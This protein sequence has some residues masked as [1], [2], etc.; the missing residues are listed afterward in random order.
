MRG[1]ALAIFVVAS[2]LLSSILVAV[3]V[4][5]DNTSATTP[6]YDVAWGYRKSHVIGASAGA[7]TLY[8]IKI[9]VYYGS[10]SDLGAA[11]YT[12]SHC[13]TDFGDI[14]FT[15]DDGVTLLDYWMESKTNSNNAV[16]WVEVADSLESSAQTIYVYYSNA[17]VATTSNGNNTFTFFDDFYSVS[18]S[19]WTITGTPTVSSHVVTVFQSAGGDAEIYSKSTFATGYALR[20][21]VNSQA[22]VGKSGCIGFGTSQRGYTWDLYGNY[23]TGSK[24]NAL[25]NGDGT[26]AIDMGNDG[27]TVHTYDL[28]RSTTQCQYLVDATSKGTQTAGSSASLYLHIFVDD[29]A[30]T[31]TILVD[32]VVIRKYIVSEPAHSTWGSEE[33]PPPAGWSPTFTSTP[34]TTL[35]GGVAYDY[36]VT[37][38]ESATVTALNL[39]AWA[40]LLH[41]GTATSPWWINGTT[42][43]AGTYTFHLKANS[44]AGTL[45]AYQNWTVTVLGWLANYNYRLAINITGSTAGSV[46]NYPIN[47]T[48]NTGVGSNSG[49]TIY[50]N[51][52]ALN[53]PND[54]RFTSSDGVSSLYLWRGKYSSSSGTWW[55]N[56]TSIPDSPIVTKFY[57]YYG[58]A[59]ATDSS[60][61]DHV[62]IFYDTFEANNFNK[63]DSATGWD[64]ATS[65]A[66]H[67]T[68]VAASENGDGGLLKAITAI[69]TR[70]MICVDAYS[71]NN[72]GSDVAGYAQ[73]PY[74]GSGG[75]AGTVYSLLMSNGNFQVYVG[76]LSSWPSNS[77]YSKNTWYGMKLGLDIINADQYAWHNG[78]YMGV[79]DLVGGTGSPITQIARI[80]CS[81][82]TVALGHFYLDDILVGNWITPEPTISSGVESGNVTYTLAFTSSA[83]TTVVNPHGYSYTAT[84]NHT[85]TF[86]KDSCNATWITVGSSN[87]TAYGAPPSIDDG[88]PRSYTVSIKAT[89]SS[90][91]NSPVYQNYTIWVYAKNQ[92]TSSA[93]TTVVN[94]NLY[95]Y[96]CLANLTVT[97]SLTGNVTGWASIDAQ[98]WVNGTPPTVAVEEYFLVSIKGHNTNSGDAYQN[99]TLH[100]YSVFAITS[101]EILSVVNPDLYEYHAIANVPVTWSVAG[102]CTSWISI[103]AQGWVNGSPPSIN[104]GFALSYVVEIHAHNDTVGDTYQNYTLWVYAELLITSSPTTLVVNPNTYSYHTVANL[105][106]TWSLA[107]NVTGWASIDVNGWVNGTPPTVTNLQYYLVE[108][109]A[110][111]TGSGNKYQ[112]FTLYVYAEL[113]ISSSAVTSAVNPDLYHYHVIANMVVTWSLAGNVTGWASIDAQGWV[114]GT[115]PSINNGFALTY[116]VEIHAYNATTG[117]VYQNFTLYI[118]AE[119]IITSSPTTSIVN[120]NTYSYSATANLTVT[121]SKTGNAT[122]IS[123]GASNGTVYGTPPSINDGKPR[124]YTV[125]LEASNIDSG[126]EYQNFTIWVY[127][128]I[129]VTSMATTSVVN[130]HS[131]LYSAV[132][133]IT[134]TWSKDSGN[135]TWISVG[136]S[137]GTVYGSP[138]S[139][140]NGLPRSYTVNLKAHN[141]YSGDAYQNYTIWVYARLNITSYATTWIANPNLYHYHATVNLTATWTLSGNVTTW[142]SVDA[143]GWING[144][145]PT[146]IINHWYV[147]V[148]KA[149]SATSGDTYQNWTLILIPMWTPT[150]TSTP[151]LSVTN[152]TLYAYHA[153]ANVSV[154]WFK[155]IG[156]SWIYVSLSTGWVSGTLLTVSTV[157]P[158]SVQ[159]R[160]HSLING[161]ETNQSFVITVYPNYYFTSIPVTSVTNPHHYFY[162][163][164]T[165]VPAIFLVTGNATWLFYNNIT[166]HISGTPPTINTTHTY[167][168][169]IA[170]TNG[171]L[172]I[173]Q[174]FTISV[175]PVGWVSTEFWT[176]ETLMIFFAA[177]FFILILIFVVLVVLKGIGG[178]R[179]RG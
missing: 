24:V 142:A 127:A 116:V 10:G 88:F 64:I 19:L 65:P 5:P 46:I 169:Q 7:G 141:T 134:A 166:G 3:I 133:N 97:W 32:W 124:S 105:T 160:A 153:T 125:N 38:N 87:G 58:Y 155:N 6:W 140:N 114:N 50:L 83:I 106:V 2:L 31:G 151:I 44:T 62:F 25:K 45:Y 57:L 117:D 73:I 107:G 61:G 173:Y 41:N 37:L 68:Y 177:L 164:T 126:D 22:A 102:N 118:Y 161:G 139:I 154:T 98:G 84:T 89:N 136:A 66:D 52:H 157:T 104:D 179:G 163:V 17:G 171:N 144:T 176:L 158:Y 20:T 48:I 11:V 119:L 170:A 86:A 99:F 49:S 94:P 103:D 138:P 30:N 123:V 13:K 33:A 162:N 77:T 150:I 76:S 79:K 130:H 34:A 12:S 9:T 159:I 1:K 132:A 81:A 113:Q 93:V 18:S 135:A 69:N 90:C 29:A 148:L 67:G 21:K 75:A 175:H 143:Q 109:E 71:T 131:Y 145:P 63:W 178:S 147:V 115:P 55:V 121:W 112:N 60:D 16:F 80:G 111:N 110:S 156:P 108:I 70:M 53:W 35:N 122:W 43:T 39:P 168:L 78:T 152:P 72:T 165:N 40:T 149:H 174:N 27:S 85:A 101:S 47:L 91:T 59:S 96:H 137:K 8:P 26:G 51:N 42:W 146:V 74:S 56:I 95:A 82:T 92:I 4:I 128:R 54:I 120:P 23:P 100:V 14:R 15:D 167:Y 172:T 129:Q 28:L 36:E